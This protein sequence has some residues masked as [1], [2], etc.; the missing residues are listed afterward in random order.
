MS[1]SEIR[2]ERRVVIAVSAVGCAIAA[3]ALL[4]MLVTGGSAYQG[5]ALI[6]LVVGGAATLLGLRRLNAQ[7]RAV[8][9]GTNDGGLFGSRARRALQRTAAICAVI[10]TAVIVAANVGGEAGGDGAW[11]LFMVALFAP[12]A[13]GITA[14]L[15]LLGD[16]VARRRH[17]R[18]G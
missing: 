18:D 6:A 7:P 16:S 12:A 4:W 2:T 9:A 8:E 10:L 13:T 3:A 1:T 11:L 5:G 14:L 17:G 15:A